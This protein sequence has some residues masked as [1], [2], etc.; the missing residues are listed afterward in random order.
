MWAQRILTGPQPG[1]PRDALLL[2]ILAGAIF[3]WNAFPPRPLR[4]AGQWLARA[5]PRRGWL[6]SLAG[7]AVGLISLALLWN[8]LSSLAGLLLW[9]AAA[10]LFVAGTARGNPRRRGRLAIKRGRRGRLAIRGVHCSPFTVHR[11]PIPAHRPLGPPPPGTDSGRLHLH[12]LQRIGHIP[13]RLSIGRVQQ[14]T[15]CA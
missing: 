9:P 12:A 3:V 14:R 5:W 6:L 7:L 1:I 15:G 2:F 4:P 13:Q 10:V 11:S 8:D